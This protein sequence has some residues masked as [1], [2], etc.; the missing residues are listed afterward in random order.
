LHRGTQTGVHAFIA[1]RMRLLVNASVDA[2]MTF[3][4]SCCENAVVVS[5]LTAVFRP[6]TEGATDLDA[7]HH[8]AKQWADGIVAC[9]HS[10]RRQLSKLLNLEAEGA[11]SHELGLDDDGDS[12]RDGSDGDDG[13]DGND[14]SIAGEVMGVVVPARLI[15]TYGWAEPARHRMADKRCTPCLFKV[16]L[17]PSAGRVDFDPSVADVCSMPTRYA[18][19]CCS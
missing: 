7:V 6:G 19:L 1:T 13:D 15:G 12:S 4:A 14:G 10:D 9:A 3:V 5:A 18:V 16:T 8:S 11:R 17:V 2:F